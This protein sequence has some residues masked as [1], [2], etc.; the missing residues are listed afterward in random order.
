MPSCKLRATSGCVPLGHVKKTRSSSLNILSATDATSLGIDINYIICLYTTELVCLYIQTNCGVVPSQ[1]LGCFWDLCI[2]THCKGI[3]DE[4]K[5]N[6]KNNC[7]YSGSERPAL[8]RQWSII[9]GVCA[10]QF[11]YHKNHVQTGHVKT[12][13]L[14]SRI[15]RGRKFNQTKIKHHSCH[16]SMNHEDSKEVACSKPVDVSTEVMFIV[17]QVG[18]IARAIQICFDEAHHSL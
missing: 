15:R 9:S 11:L 17:L 13:G 6:L 14:W 18:W 16:E 7:Q 5:A 8:Q 10:F 1:L 12:E 3:S 4:S 2:Q